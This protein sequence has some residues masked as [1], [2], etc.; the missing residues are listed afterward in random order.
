MRK[1]QLHAKRYACVVVSSQTSSVANKRPSIQQLQDDQSPYVTDLNL[2]RLNMRT[3]NHAKLFIEW[4]TRQHQR[5]LEIAF[6]L[7][8]NA[9]LPVYVVLEIGRCDL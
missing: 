4:S 8:N 9:E 2:I 5:L 7:L 6:V 3:E 1:Q